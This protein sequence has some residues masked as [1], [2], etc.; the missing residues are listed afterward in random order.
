M[1]KFLTLFVSITVCFALKIS[2]VQADDDD[3]TIIAERR[4][5]GRPAPDSNSYTETYESIPDIN[6]SASEF[7]PTPDRW[8]QFYAGKWYDPYNQ[9][10]LKGDIPVFGEPG[11]EWFFEGSI[12]SDSTAERRRLPAPVGFGVSSRPQSNDLFGNGNQFVFAQTFLTSFALIK[13]DTSFKPPDYEFRFTPAFNINYVDAGEVGV[14]RADPFRGETRTDTHFGIQELFVDTHLGNVS[15]RYDFIS[16]RIGIQRF[17]SDFRGFIFADEA[18]G[19]RLFGNLDNN[20]WQYNL[21]W[22]SRL[23]KDTNSGLNTVFSPRYEQVVVANLFRQDTPLPGHTLQANI[24]HREDMAGEHGDHYDENGFLVRPAPFGDRRPTNIS[25]TYFGLTGDGHF[26]RINSTSALY[27]VTGSESHNPIAQRRTDIAAFMLAQ[28]IS[29]DIDWIRLRGSVLWASGDDDPY[30][31]TATGFDGIFENPNFAGGNLSFFQR[32]GLPLIAGGGVG[33]TNPSSFFPNLRANKTEGQSNFVNP[34]LRL[35][36]VGVDF[37]L[38]QTMKLINNL[39]FLQFDEVE[40]LAVLRHDVR[41]N[42]DIGYD[43]STGII[44]RPFLNNNVQVR[45]GTGF[46]FPD[47]GLKRL[48]GEEVLFHAFT[49]LLL[50]Y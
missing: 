1:R 7:V 19:V 29:Y 13:G 8:R 28:E 18:P 41:F 35:Y 46:L 9:N 11:E 40:S 48:Y 16:T 49:N 45:L 31:D 24:V 42:R 27:F 32:E 5:P 6:S 15:D 22:F 36:N 3:G 50:Q 23:D 4:I 33:L 37:E 38:T 25:S 14:L 2:P 43:L 21:A 17:L 26:N 10:I 20:I 39:S 47:E 44:Y 12:I 30:D 34:G